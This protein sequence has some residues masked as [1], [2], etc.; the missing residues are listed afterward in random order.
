MHLKNEHGRHTIIITNGKEVPE[1]VLITAS[2]ITASTKTGKIAVDYT[3]RKNVKRIN[4]ALP[5][6]VTYVNYNTLYVTPNPHEEL[7]L[8]GKSSQ[9]N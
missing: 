3:I 5:G 8:N 9:K 2:E 7:C 6:L 1:S 4:G